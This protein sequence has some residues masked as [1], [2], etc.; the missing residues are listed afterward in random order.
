MNQQTPMGWP[1]LKVKCSETIIIVIGKLGII[2]AANTFRLKSEM[3][4]IMTC[5]IPSDLKKEKKKKGLL[6]RIITNFL[7]ATEVGSF[8]VNPSF[9]YV[10]V[11]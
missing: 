9:L 11:P 10:F 6:S 2:A 8:L 4:T 7:F 5:G 3:W 1:S